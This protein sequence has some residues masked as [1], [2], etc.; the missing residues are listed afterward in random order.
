MVVA[1]RSA[2]VIAQKM[3]SPR[4]AIARKQT[5]TVLRS[6]C[7]FAASSF[8]DEVAPIGHG[9]A[10]NGA[11]DFFVAQRLQRS[12]CDDDLA[13]EKQ[14]SGT[15]VG[16]DFASSFLQLC[17]R[18]KPRSARVYPY[19]PESP[20]LGQ[21]LRREGIGFTRRP[22]GQPI[23]LPLEKRCGSAARPR[24]GGWA[25]E[26]QAR[27]SSGWRGRAA[28][29]WTWGCCRWWWRGKNF[30]GASVRER[31]TGCG[32]DAFSAYGVGSGKRGGA[33]YQPN[34]RR[35]TTEN[36]SSIRRYPSRERSAPPGSSYHPTRKDELFHNVDLHQIDAV[37]P[38]WVRAAPQGHKTLDGVPDRRV[39]LSL[40]E[41]KSVQRFLTR[42]LTTRANAVKSLVTIVPSR[43]Y[44]A[45][46]VALL[47]VCGHS[48]E[49]APQVRRPG[50]ASSRQA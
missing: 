33:I 50:R 17:R 27:D 29:W 30:C 34:R 8:F 39:R 3:T 35:S 15:S 48:Q 22:L 45:T 11:R 2:S 7:S 13:E 31:D 21:F 43:G 1:V 14:R 47:T 20:A 19:R 28:G 32:G 25:S 10:F 16:R 41:P 26:L 38:S 40:T 12:R 18:D 49:L 44:F 4:R 46:V 6:A 9:V 36:R 23:P 24:G 5:A 42:T 37:G